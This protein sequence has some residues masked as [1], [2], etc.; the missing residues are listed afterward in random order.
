MY[1]CVRNTFQ[2][3]A[4][5]HSRTFL[6]PFS[7]EMGSNERIEIRMNATYVLF[8]VLAKQTIQSISL[9]ERKSEGIDLKTET[10]PK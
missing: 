9:N 1:I 8:H 3:I 4:G 5:N 10:T 2:K 6:T 7:N